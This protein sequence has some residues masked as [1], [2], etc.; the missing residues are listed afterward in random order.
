M[1]MTSE[2]KNKNKQ[3]PISRSVKFILPPENIQPS[4]KDMLAHKFARKTVKEL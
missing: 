3:I 1:K 2:T 4:T